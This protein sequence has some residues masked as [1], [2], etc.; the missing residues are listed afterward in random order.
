MPIEGVVLQMKAM[1]IDA[2]VNFPFP[3]PPDREALKSA[4]KMLIH[5]GALAN[6]ESHIQARGQITDVG[7]MMSLFPLSPRFSRMLVAG[8]QGGCLAYVIAIVAALSVGDPFLR[9]DALEQ[10]E[11]GDE[12]HASEKEVTRLRR[13]AF[14]QAQNVHSSLGDY[15][16]DVFKVLSVVG[17]YEYAGGGHKFCA[18]QFVRIKVGT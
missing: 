15:R 1:H 16:S 18:E 4:E 13:K 7:R 3:S 5:L 8:Q 10:G 14:F 9:D 11:S 2:V 6:G 17:A 12:D